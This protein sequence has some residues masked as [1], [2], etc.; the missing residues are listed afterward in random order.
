[1]TTGHHLLLS[2]KSHGVCS[3]AW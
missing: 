1:M 2:A 3:G